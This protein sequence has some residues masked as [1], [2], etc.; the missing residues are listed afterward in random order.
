MGC[1]RDARLRDE[2]IR[3]GEAP[4]RRIGGVGAAASRA[5]LRAFA[6][7]S[8]RFIPFVAVDPYHEY[9]RSGRCYRR[10]SAASIRPPSRAAINELSQFGSLMEQ[11]FIAATLTTS[12]T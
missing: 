6:R 8:Q 5:S 2:I 7:S 3:R 9:R 12:K 4:G 1:R 11:Q 10:T